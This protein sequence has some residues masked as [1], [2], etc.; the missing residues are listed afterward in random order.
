MHKSHSRIDYFLVSG[1]LTEMVA[2]CNIGV[3]ALSDHAPV[4]LTVR[5]GSSSPSVNRWRLNV[6]FL[7]DPTHKIAVDA[8]LKD[9]FDQNVGSTERLGTVWEASKAYLRGYLISQSSYLKKMS[10]KKIKDLESQIKI[11]ESE[12]S[13]C[14]SECKFKE[15][16][17]LKY[18]L[19]EIYNKRAELL[20][21]KAVRRQANC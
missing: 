14:Y 5:L 11:K 2:D 7:Q 10:K 13:Q 3:I 15:I 19:N 8:L 4:E 9:F 20:F 12:L 6:S 18:Q 16:C 17:K 1:T 21:M